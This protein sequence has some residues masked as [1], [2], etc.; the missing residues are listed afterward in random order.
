MVQTPILQIDKW[1]FHLP[2]SRR[3]KTICNSIIHSLCIGFDIDEDALGIC[4][5]NCSEFELAN[6]DQIQ[7]DIVSQAEGIGIWS[8]KFDT[9]IMNPPFGTKRNK[10]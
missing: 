5:E 3:Y 6:I 7:C 4:A 2:S 9:V 1:Q 8:K 10:G